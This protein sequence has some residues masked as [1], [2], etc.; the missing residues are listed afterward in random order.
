MKDQD[1][2]NKSDWHLDDLVFWLDCDDQQA[3]IL[4]HAASDL[5]K[6]EVGDQVYLRGLL[7]LSNYCGK[8]CFYCG[9]RRGNSNV[10]R[11]AMEKDEIVNA[12][13]YAYDHDYGSVV[14]QSGELSSPAFIDHIDWLLKTIREISDGRLRVTLS[15]GEQSRET[16]LRWKES[17]AHRY[18]LRIESSD[19][20]LYSKLHP[21]DDV[22][23]YDRRLEA[24]Y[25]LKELGYQVGTGVMI[26]LPFQTTEHL[27]KD[28]L[29]MK[30]FDVDMCGMGP[31]IEHEQTPLYKYSDLLPSLDERFKKSLKMIALL[32]LMMKDVNIAATTALQ[33]L[34]PMGREKA[35]QVGA[36]VV[37]PNITPVK[38]RGNYLLYNNKPCTQDS[39]EQCSNCLDARVN[40]AGSFI[41]Y[42]EWGDA[43]HFLKRQNPDE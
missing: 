2:I 5:K 40:M 25:L 20:A 11:Y 9:I 33:T 29:F 27:A 21:N 13:Q 31:Y 36:N 12:I 22:H 14:V 38:Y 8:N 35:I 7:E 6:R 43:K 4:F 42:K 19:R 18:L 41:A 16:F 32:R 30:S 15:C 34:D 17:G 23:S 24:L 28:L 3:K 39:A 37:M 10:D 26:G 1:L